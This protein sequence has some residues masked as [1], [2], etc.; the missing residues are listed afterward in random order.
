MSEPIR[1]IE[2]NVHRFQP[3]LGT[4]LEDVNFEHAETHL[5]NTAHLY[6][7]II[8]QL[9]ASDQHWTGLHSLVAAMSSDIGTLRDAAEALSNGATLEL[10]PPADL[11]ASLTAQ[12]ALC[13]EIAT[14]AAAR[15][16]DDDQ[17]ND[18]LSLVENVFGSLERTIERA[19]N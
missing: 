2:P 12:A 4:F 5:R 17:Q 13:R 9:L 15:I 18:A 8:Q 14:A 1:T 3:I 19:F 10:L 7:L 6:A 11:A 16:G